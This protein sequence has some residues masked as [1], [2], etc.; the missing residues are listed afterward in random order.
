M[1]IKV[2]C[3]TDCNTRRFAADGQHHTQ[4]AGSD[5]ERRTPHGEGKRQRTGV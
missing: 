5:G 2:L 4:S 3:G 1:K